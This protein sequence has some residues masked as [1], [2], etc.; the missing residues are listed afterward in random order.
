MAAQKMGEGHEMRVR[1]KK[2]PE[3]RRTILSEGEV[4]LMTRRVRKVIGPILGELSSGYGIDIEDSVR[5]GAVAA[6][7]REARE[8]RGMDLKAAAKAMRVPQYRLRYIEKCSVKNVR[9]SEL[10]AYIDFLGL[11]EWFTRW[12]TANPKLAAKLG[13]DRRG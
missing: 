1:P 8:G 10:N 12:R 4:R 2:T 9:L 3:L 6:R 5:F 13:A 11:G 7:L